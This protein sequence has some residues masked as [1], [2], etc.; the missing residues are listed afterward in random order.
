MVWNTTPL[1][2]QTR[3]MIGVADVNHYFLFNPDEVKWQISNNTVSRDTI[4]GRVVQ[5]L[6]SRVEQMTVTG[7]AGSREELQ[8]F[9]LN[10]KKIMKYQIE[11]Q[12]SVHF[13]VPSRKW[14]F[15]VYV[16]NVSSLGWDYA[17]T[18]YPY[19][20]T[21]LVQEDLAGLT[22]KAIEESALER[23]AQGIGYSEELHGG[24][25][26]NALSTSEVY[27]NSVGF[28]KSS[29]RPIEDGEGEGAPPG[30]GGGGTPPSG[31]TE[32]TGRVDTRGTPAIQQVYE[33][34][35]NKYPFSSSAGIF[36][37]KQIKDTTTWSQHSWANAWDIKGS[38]TL[39]NEIAQ[40]LLQKARSKELPIAQILWEHQNLLTGGYVYDHT[41]HIHVS[42]DPMISGVPPC[43]ANM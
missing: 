42:G 17:A 39:L 33:Y 22:K 21:L 20:L 37:C 5:L 41:D 36:V 26:E 30:S 9:A 19:E 40:D 24:N 25:S 11:L 32:F 43:A 18:S 6:S 34:V 28:V 13:K 14:D 7:R 1:P 15:K 16:Q 29:G 2:T 3:A 35:T 12:N 4:G 31:Y 8:K 10:M 23:L 38:T 27:L